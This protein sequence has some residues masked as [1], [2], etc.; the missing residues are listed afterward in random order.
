M[1]IDGKIALPNKR[2]LKLSS[3]EDFRRVHELRNYCDGILV[4]IDTIIIDNPKLTVKP[5][6]VIKPQ[7]PT[8]IILDSKGRI[9]DDSKV[10]NNDAETYIVMGEKYKKL[11]KDF[12]YAEII[13]CPT[14]NAGDYEKIDLKML[15]GILKNKGIEN[16]LV[17]GGETVIFN[18]IKNSL[19]DELN[20][21]ISS[22]I[23]GGITSPTLA[24]GE[25]FGIEN[26]VLN[27]KL[28]S[29]EGLGDGILLKYLFR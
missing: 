8:R 28:Y 29:F 27:L 26:D 19:V 23:I 21:Y 14:I 11:K 22:I 7:N 4:G 9:P 25:G 18:F 10:L 24:G 3:L 16:L 1:S 5:E 2:P 17:E 20:V 6:F 12:K 13:Y 15:L